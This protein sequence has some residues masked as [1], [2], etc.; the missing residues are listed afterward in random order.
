MRLLAN[1]P[2]NLDKRELLAQFIARRP[3]LDEILRELGQKEPR[4]HLIVATRGMGKTTLLHRLRYAIEDDPAL[5]ARYVAIQFPE[6]QNN[7]S[8]IAD[9]YLNCLDAL[10]D[11]YE[12]RGEAGQ[13]SRIDRLV[14]SVK[15]SPNLR[16]DAREGFVRE[17]KALGRGL[18][19]PVDNIERIIED[20]PDEQA[21]DF[22]GLLMEEPLVLIGAS[23]Q[24]V[25]ATFQH[26]RA[27][28]E[29][30][31]E[32]E[33]GG[34]TDEETRA[35]LTGLSE[36][37]G[38]PQVK[39]WTEEHPTRLRTLRVLT[40]GNPRTTVLLYGLLARDAAI[41]A[42]AGLETL[43]DLNT[44]L[45]KARFD[46]HSVQSQRVLD[47][48]ATHWDP[49]TAAEIAKLTR[50]DVNTSSALLA[51]LVKQGVAEK[52]DLFDSVRAGF[53]V[54]ERFFNIWYIMRYSTRRVKQRVSWLVRFLQIFYSQPELRERVEQYLR[55]GPAADRGLVAAYARSVDSPEH[56][57]ALQYR[58]MEEGRV[59]TS[60][61]RELAELLDLRGDGKDLLPAQERIEIMEQVR[62]ALEA[63]GAAGEWWDLVGG[64]LSM[65]P[66]EKLELAQSIVGKP[67]VLERLREERERFGRQ[68]YNPKTAQAWCVAI[69]GGLVFGLENAEDGLAAAL[70]LRSAELRADM[71][72]RAK[73]YEAARECLDSE[74]V[75]RP[76]DAG[77]HCDLGRLLG[78]HMPGKAEEA[79]LHFDEAI[80]LDPGFARAWCGLGNLLAQ[81]PG[82]AEEAERAYRTS[83]ELDAEDA[84]LWQ[85]LGDLLAEIPAKAEEAERAYR[86]SIELEP[87]YTRP[88]NC[89][90][91]LL[92]NLPGKAEE[93]ER[94]YRTSI[95]IDPKDALPWNNLGILL[96]K[97]P[98]KTEE[99]ERA[100]RTS[101]ELDPKDAR[102]WNVLGILLARLPGRAEEAERAYRT[103]IELDP[104]GAGPWNNLGSLLANLPGKAEE[105]ERALRT[106]SKLDPKDALIWNNLGIL[107]ATLPGKA[108]EAERAFRSSIEL[109][110]KN[111]R[112]WTNL[113]NLLAKLPGKTEK[114]E[115]AYRKSIELDPE[116]ALPWNNLG[117]LL[118]DL[119]GKA[120][121]AERAYRTSIELDPQYA[122]SWNNLAV[123]LHGQ[124][125]EE[126]AWLQAGRHAAGSEHGTTI[127]D[128]QYEFLRRTLDSKGFLQA[129][130]SLQRFLAGTPP[131]FHE[132]DWQGVL[133]FAQIC[134]AAN[135]AADLV[136]LLDETSWEGVAYGDRWRP[137]REAVNA[138]AVGT[139][140]ALLDVAPEIRN[141]ALE[142]LK[143]IAPDIRRRSPRGSPKKR[144]VKARRLT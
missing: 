50:Y 41:S 7:V 52:V 140:D 16:Q 138:A 96:A 15:G 11:W 68:F 100:F 46:E 73:R 32:H 61:R 116:Y 45:Y 47:A 102:S 22:R 83:I 48:L 127:S 123:L 12:K 133:D 86:K 78:K 120:E 36:V 54:A 26:D 136:A 118:A 59:S 132:L 121:E 95:E 13:S 35:V 29:F 107:L 70:R 105:A 90:G 33:M 110:P 5:N 108:E 51:R 101:I 135:H 84:W 113:G 87:R 65:S 94:V 40:G 137:L 126:Q 66:A 104:Q 106:S 144:R 128:N 1:N 3:L 57:L 131:E 8:D 4:H 91:T 80:R 9:F 14:D 125:E 6:E 114:A 38:H 49:A 23:T 18:V 44:P 139:S 30:F 37:M 27:F 10:A 97:L 21:W 109:D 112:S 119:P 28:Y 62:C 92:G 130:A 88:W 124:E 129:A 63:S 141:P 134:I 142:I 76:N 60:V 77:L 67:E 20:L 19:L 122:A 39:R 42:E 72:I 31:H 74:L 79:R 99:A 89:L 82:K 53:Q 64:S 81:Q 69:R 56:R 58:L 93:A 24:P 34:L 103:S 71:L 143:Q 2:G 115:R 55:A 98:G 17:V 111:A 43:L 85:N 25:D 117:N 75:C